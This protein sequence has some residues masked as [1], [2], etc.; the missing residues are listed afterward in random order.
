M[1][2][3]FNF[4]TFKAKQDFEIRVVNK[5]AIDSRITANNEMKVESTVYF[6]K[7]NH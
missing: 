6:N 4:C 7:L 5:Y 2:Y 1:L 3:F